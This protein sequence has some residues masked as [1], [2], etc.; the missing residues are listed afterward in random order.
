LP[1]V[2]TGHIHILSDDRLLIPG[3]RVATAIRLLA[4]TLHPTIAGR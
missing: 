2:R 3:P 1:A 4:E